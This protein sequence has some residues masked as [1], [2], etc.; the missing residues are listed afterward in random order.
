M[1]IGQSGAPSRPLERTTCRVLIART[2]VGAG[3]VGSPDSPV[4][5]RTATVHVRCVISF[6]IWRSR[7]LLLGAG[8][9]TGHCPVH[10]GQSGA[11]SRPLERATC[12]ALITRTTVGAGAV[13]SPDSLVNFSRTP[14]SFSREQP[15]HRRPA[16]RTGH[17]PVCQARADVGCSQLI[18]FQIRFSFLCTISSTW[19]SMLVLKK[20]FTKSRNV[21]C[22]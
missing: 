2:T 22:L 8:W 14:L 4:H 12:H 3:T 11:P 18:L 5:H 21:P 17:Y 10:T 16:W 1:H 9:R 20:Q 13:G 6:H 15:V 19:T 7:S